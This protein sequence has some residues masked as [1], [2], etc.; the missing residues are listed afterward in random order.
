MAEPQNQ[1][2]DN[3]KENSQDQVALEL[4]KFVAVQTGYGKGGSNA[5]FGAK[6]A[7]SPEAYA[8]ALIELF[9]RCRKA[10][11]GE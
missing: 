5:G 6:T 3:A 11:K 10:V 8:D 7:V 2:Q 9:H 4:M 1:N